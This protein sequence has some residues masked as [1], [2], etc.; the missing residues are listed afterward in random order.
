MLNGQKE[1]LCLLNLAS[2][3]VEASLLL[4]LLFCKACFEYVCYLFI[5]L[6]PLILLRSLSHHHLQFC[7]QPMKL[8]K[9]M[10]CD[11]FLLLLGGGEGEGEGVEE[12]SLVFFVKRCWETNSALFT[13]HKHLTS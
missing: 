9:Y 10:R 13:F 6:D 12:Y 8:E 2:H 5:F 4:P 7:S 11:F 3:L 1:H